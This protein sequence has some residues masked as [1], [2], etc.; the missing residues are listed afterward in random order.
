MKRKKENGAKFAAQE[1]YVT[2]AEGRNYFRCQTQ[3]RQPWQ[4]Q[5]QLQQQHVCMP[6]Q[7][8]PKAMCKYAMQFFC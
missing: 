3:Q 5:Q 7:T 8:M 1:E 2:T 6:V 4:Q